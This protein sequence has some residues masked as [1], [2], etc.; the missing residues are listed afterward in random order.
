MKRSVEEVYNEKR[1]YDPN[2]MKGIKGAVG[3][4]N[5]MFNCESFIALKG[6]INYKMSKGKDDEQHSMKDLERIPA[7]KDMI[8]NEK[9]KK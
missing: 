7:Y 9:K 6:H 3:C 5:C 4:Q 1:F 2:G 8:E